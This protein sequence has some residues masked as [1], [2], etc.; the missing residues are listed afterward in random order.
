[1]NST[2]WT[3]NLQQLMFSAIAAGIV[4][5]GNSAVAILNAGSF[6]IDW[7]ST[8]AIFCGSFLSCIILFFGSNS[9]GEVLGKGK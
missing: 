8:I 4:G 2:K 5:A 9:K 3:I 7:K 6:E 1:M